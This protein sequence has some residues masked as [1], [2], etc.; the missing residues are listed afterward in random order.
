M[1]NMH[2]LDFEKQQKLNAN[3]TTY[4][5]ADRSVD[6]EEH[7]SRYVSFLN[8]EKYKPYQIRGK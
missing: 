6:Q 7:I 1:L 2:M 5:S 3:T 8:S 4:K